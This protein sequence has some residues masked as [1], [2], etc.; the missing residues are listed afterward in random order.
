MVITE[1]KQREGA[2]ISRVD[3]KKHALSHSVT[4]LDQFECLLHE[5]SCTSAVEQIL[6]LFL[7][8]FVNLITIGAIGDSTS[9]KARVVHIQTVAITTLTA[10]VTSVDGSKTE[11]SPKMNL[12][13]VMAKKLLQPQNEKCLD[14]LHVLLV[15]KLSLLCVVSLLAQLCAVSRELSVHLLRQSKWTTSLTKCLRSCSGK[16]SDRVETCCLLRI[17]CAM[18]SKL[19]DVQTE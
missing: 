1:L 16:N 19:E 10:L 9:V 2:S 4:V 17:L 12:A 7:F 5:F 15:N 8:C 14:V 6:I 11:S 3:K 13:N 18:M